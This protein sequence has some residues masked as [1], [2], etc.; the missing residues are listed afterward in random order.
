MRLEDALEMRRGYLTRHLG[1]R[2]PAVA[3]SWE[4]KFADAIAASPLEPDDQELVVKLV[5]HLLGTD[6]RSGG[7][8]AGG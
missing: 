7:S 4:D 1:L 5:R 8:G 2:D 3:S 6:A